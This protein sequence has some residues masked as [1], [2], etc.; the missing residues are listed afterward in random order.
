MLSTGAI[1]DAI[2]LGI[3]GL[4]TLAGQ[5]HFTARITPGLAANIEQMTP[6]THRA[7]SFLGIDYITVCFLIG[8]Q[9]LDHDLR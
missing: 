5:A 4:Y 2:G 3:A 7:F 8:P 1:S 9:Y 6:N